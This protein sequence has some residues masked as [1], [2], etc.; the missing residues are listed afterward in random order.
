MSTLL[1][2]TAPR[3]STSPR[4][5]R[6]SLAAVAVL[7]A[8]VPFATACAAGFDATTQHFQQGPGNGSTGIMR[9]N[10]V[11]VVLDQASGTAEVIGAVSNTSRDTTDRLT[12]VLAGSTSAVVRG[13]APFSSHACQNVSISSGVTVFPGGSTASFGLR[14]CPALVLRGGTWQPGRATTVSLTFSDGGTLKV[15]ALVMPNTGLFAEYNL[16]GAPSPTATA[17]AVSAVH[18]AASRTGAAT[19]T[20]TPGQASPTGH[21]SAT[22][23]D[24]AAGSASPAASASGTASDSADRNTTASTTN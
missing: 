11:W 1:P 3:R 17:M 5:G 24:S 16:N 10:N 9:V 8:T 13:S 12:G 15:N 21:A 20:P 22:P 4:R 23:S 18:P 6:A 14:D 7:V 2:R 19:P